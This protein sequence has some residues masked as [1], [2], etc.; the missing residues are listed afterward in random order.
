MKA[1]F[2]LSTAFRRGFQNVLEP[3]G[4]DRLSWVA[5]LTESGERNFKPRIMPFDPLNRLR[6]Q[7]KRRNLML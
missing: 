1:S 6:A 3:Q 7:G 4:R 2:L 5:R